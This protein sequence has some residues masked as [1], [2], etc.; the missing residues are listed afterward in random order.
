[1]ADASPEPDMSQS[2][3][4]PE[5]GGEGMAYEN[6]FEQGKAAEK[7]AMSV[8]NMLNLQAMPTRKYLESAVVPLLVQGLQLLVRE[9]PSDPVEYLAAFLLKNN[10]NNPPH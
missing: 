7:A 10:P 3:A 5:G 6:P 9:R 2:Q 8:H 4:Q 1:M